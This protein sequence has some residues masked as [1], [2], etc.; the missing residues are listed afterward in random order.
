MEKTS[1]S[2]K[3]TNDQQAIL[4][5]MLKTGNYRPLKVE[6]TKIAVAGEDCTIALYTSGKCLVQGKKAADFVTFFLEPF[7][8]GSAELGYEDILHP[9]AFSAHM[10]IDESGKGD[11]FGPMVVAAAYVDPELAQTMREMN[12]RDSKTIT[13]DNKALDMGRDLRKLLGRRFSVVR[14]GPEAYNRLYAKMRNVNRILAWGHAR[15]IENMLDVLPECPRAISDQFG[16]KQQVERALMKKGRKIELV[17]R[18]KAESDLAV[19][20]AS[21]IAREIFLRALKDMEKQY[22]LPFPKGA[23][24]AVKET[25]VELVKKHKP[26]I[27]LQTAKCHFKTAD[28]VLEKLKLKRAV[29]GPEGQA[30]SKPFAGKWTKGNRSQGSG[31]GDQKE[32]ETDGAADEVGEA[33]DTE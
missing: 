2:Y 1:F 11:F 21:I 26:V 29:L 10:G 24:E 22:S 13:S 15:C 19:A 3:L 32:T 28:M 7:V 8:L 16:S 9:E 14:I 4:I 33:E 30:V 25:A 20:A 12:V 31:V 5:D 17:Q 18:H 27:L 6:Y 23:S